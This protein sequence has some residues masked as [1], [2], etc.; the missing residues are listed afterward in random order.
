MS[1]KATSFD[2]LPPSL[3]RQNFAGQT[4]SC[5]S[6]TSPYAER[7][8]PD[9]R[10]K[11]GTPILTFPLFRGRE[12]EMMANGIGI[13]A[14]SRSYRRDARYMMQNEIAATPSGFVN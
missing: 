6:K 3:I 2:R 13:T 10:M 8:F 5:F 4:P 7:F 9:C 1:G 11:G 14:V 12:L